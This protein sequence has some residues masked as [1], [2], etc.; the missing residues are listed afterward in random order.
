VGVGTPILTRC[1]V[2]RGRISKPKSHFKQIER[3]AKDTIAPDR[4]LQQQEH[5]SENP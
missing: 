3:L 5:P 2:K 4:A 1:P